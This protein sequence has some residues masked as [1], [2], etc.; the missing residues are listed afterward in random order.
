QRVRERLVAETGG[1]PLAPLGL[2]PAVSEAQRAGGFPPPPPAPGTSPLPERYPRR[3][4]GPPEPTPPVM[5]LAA[6]DPTGDATLLWRAA[7]SMSLG[8]EAASPAADEQ[9][10]EIGAGVHFRHPLVRS[11]AYAA[12]STEGRR[13]A[14]QA[15][16]DATDAQRDPD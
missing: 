13:A 6:T 7:Q 2:G 4:Q 8:H 1:E 5:L 16:A 12:A 11:A 10:L 3:I 14:H 15:L 9:L